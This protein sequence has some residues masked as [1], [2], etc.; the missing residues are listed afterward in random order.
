MGNVKYPHDNGPGVGENQG[1]GSGLEYPLEEHP[2]VHIVEVI[3]VRN[4]LNQLQGHEEGQHRPGNG[5][6]HCF[7]QAL[8]HVENAAVPCLGR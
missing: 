1:G 5:E 6:H 4:K 3:L 2:G 7:G 8:N